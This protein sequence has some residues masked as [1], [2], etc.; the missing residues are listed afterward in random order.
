[1]GLLE[2]VL[3]RVEM[4]VNEEYAANL[5]QGSSKPFVQTTFVKRLR[6]YVPSL[7]WIPNYQLSMYVFSCGRIPKGPTH[8]ISLGSAVI[9]WQA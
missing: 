2:M 8:P 5:F 9:S 4:S 1:M 7:A 6:Y 3:V